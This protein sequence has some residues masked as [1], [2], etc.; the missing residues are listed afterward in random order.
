MPCGL[1]VAIATRLEGPSGVVAPPLVSGCETSLR[2]RLG[3][4]SVTG[5]SGCDDNSVVVATASADVSCNSSATSCRACKCDGPLVD[6][7]FGLSK[8]TWLTVN[9]LTTGESDRPVIPVDDLFS[10][11]LSATV[12]IATSKT[13]GRGIIQRDRSLTP[14]IHIILQ[15]LFAREA[16][17]HFSRSLPLG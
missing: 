15:D 4:R 3:I 13:Y 11:Y 9:R 14:Q 1:G 16:P 10:R 2:V 8:L 7:L 5:G 6:R 17:T 12:T